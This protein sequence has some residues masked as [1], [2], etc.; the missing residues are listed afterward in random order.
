MLKRLILAA[1][2]TI[3]L[4][5]CV[6]TRVAPLDSQQ[7]GALQGGTIAVSHREKPTFMAQTAGKATFALLGAAAM[8]AAGNK[9]V[10]DNGVEDPAVY[11]GRK[12]TEDLALMHLLTLVDAGTVVADSTDVAKLARQYSKADL[13]LDVQTVDWNFIYFPTDWNSY[14]VIYRTKVRLID[15]KKA[16]LLAEGY[17]ERVPGKTGDAPSHDQLVGN[18][19]AGLKQRLAKHAESCLEELRRTTLSGV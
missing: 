2:A 1:T 15:T 14:Q 8:M 19:A 9:I 12:L 4:G 6:S 18:G 13:L 7:I 16:K 17:C 3:A 5:G 10:A 11:I